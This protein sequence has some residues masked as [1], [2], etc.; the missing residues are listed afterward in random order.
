MQK[1]EVLAVISITANSCELW[2]EI[3]EDLPTTCGSISVGA[4]IEA[5]AMGAGNGVLK[6]IFNRILNNPFRWKAVIASSAAA[7][8][9][10]VLSQINWKKAWYYIE[11]SLKDRV[12]WLF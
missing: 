4:A 9:L 5:D 10:N 2:G 12:T 1:E 6:S 8:A 3:L 11:Q 7:S